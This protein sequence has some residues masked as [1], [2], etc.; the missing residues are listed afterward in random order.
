[1]LLTKR[2]L[3][4][5]LKQ[6]ES[7]LSKEEATRI[8]ELFFKEMLLALKDGEEVKLQGF[9]N[10]MV[11]RKKARPGRNPKTGEPAIIKARSVVTFYPSEK[12]MD[13]VAETVDTED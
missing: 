11:R 1:M 13:R 8:V 3:I 5:V 12:L 2:E 9:G 6:Q 10:F 4:A 7:D